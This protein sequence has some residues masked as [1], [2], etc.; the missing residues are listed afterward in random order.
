MG[1]AGDG[2]ILKELFDNT[3]ESES[4]DRIIIVSS[5]WGP[6]KRSGVTGV[7]DAIF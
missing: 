5:N 6:G 4:E 7:F 3:I 1:G 2:E